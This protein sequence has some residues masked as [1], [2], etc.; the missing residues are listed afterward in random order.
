MRAAI[1]PTALVGAL[2]AC[3]LDTM[4]EPAEGERIFSENCTACH[5]YRGEGGA[6][7]GGQ[8]APELTGLAAANDGVFP[9]ARA[10]SHIDGYGRG[11]VSAD[12]MPEFGG[13]LEGET[14]PVDIDGVMTPTPRP[15][16]ALLAYLESIQQ[17]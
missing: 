15:L 2:A 8:Q 14:V 12:V 9:R 6:L 1:L 10:L 17:P 5:G 4:P 13:L 11:K 3:A 7:I 16:A